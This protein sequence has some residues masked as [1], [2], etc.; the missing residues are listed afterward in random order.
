MNG[1]ID[2]LHEQGRGK[3]FS[4]EIRSLC[5]V[6]INTCLQCRTCASVCPFYEAMGH[7]PHTLF[8]KIQYGLRQEVLTS[9]AIWICV[10][11]NTCAS[12]CPAGID[13]VAAMDVLRQ[14]ALEANMP[15]PEEDV[16]NF[17]REVLHSIERYG[18]THKLEI[19]LRY[20]IKSG[21]LLADLDTGVVMLAKRKLDLRPSKV[22]A[23]NEIKRLFKKT[24]QET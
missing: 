6:N 7:A 16:L 15:I 10:G 22:H 4:D 12:Q 11:C 20:K 17:H 14:L 19:M 3:S 5:G 23:V 24:W 8:R 13:I 21:H 18:R 9:S 1:N 2:I